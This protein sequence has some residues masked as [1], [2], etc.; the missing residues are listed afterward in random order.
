MRVG[1][2]LDERCRGTVSGEE[3]S[4]DVKN[5]LAMALSSVHQPKPCGCSIL[6]Y[7]TD[8]VEAVGTADQG[9][10]SDRVDEVSKSFPTISSHSAAKG[11]AGRCLIRQRAPTA[12]VTSLTKPPRHPSYALLLLYQ[13]PPELRCIFVFVPSSSKDGVSNPR[14]CHGQVSYPLAMGTHVAIEY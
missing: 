4:S 11:G 14:R 7:D 8:S 12:V 2:M 10:R 1:E 13:V 9:G 6:R 5:E 3:V